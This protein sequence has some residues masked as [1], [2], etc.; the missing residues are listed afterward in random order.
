MFD[1]LFMIKNTF[2]IDKTIDDQY[3]YIIGKIARIIYNSKNKL[4]IRKYDWRNDAIDIEIRSYGYA[5]KNAE[6]AIKELR[7][8]YRE[9]DC[10]VT[11]YINML[12][13]DKRNKVGTTGVLNK[14]WIAYNK[15]MQGFVYIK[16]NGII[17]SVTY[18]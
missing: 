10:L 7:N 13:I 2:N 9:G 3:F 17:E 5:E 16:E 4:F 11:D 1:R 18:Q 15:N 12:I 6:S 8:F 14:R